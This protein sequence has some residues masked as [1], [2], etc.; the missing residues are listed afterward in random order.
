MT[1]LQKPRLD[2]K[3]CENSGHLYRGMSA[4]CLFCGFDPSITQPQVPRI[5]RDAFQIIM[6]DFRRGYTDEWLYDQLFPV[7]P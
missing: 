5:S 1:E 6:N 3:T 2:Q 7:H 4:N